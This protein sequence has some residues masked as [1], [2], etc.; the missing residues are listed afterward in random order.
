MLEADNIINNSL[1]EILNDSRNKLMNLLSLCESPIE[2]IF[3]MK[4]YSFFYRINASTEGSD[5]KILNKYLTTEEENIVYSDSNN[6]NPLSKGVF[7]DPIGPFLLKTEGFLFKANG[8]TYRI[9]PQLALDLGGTKIRLDF[10]LISEVY[11]EETKESKYNKFCIECD[12]HEFH[13]EKE[14]RSSDNKRMRILTEFEW[15]TIRYTGTQIYQLTDDGI[16]EFENSLC[17][18]I[19]GKP[20]QIYLFRK[21]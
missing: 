21:L 13:K 19:T 10:A 18:N 16:A 20:S 8:I 15:Q 11:S 4:L 17:R 12:G 9:Y 14:Q 2:K 5:F 7:Q 1:S 6:S 3:L